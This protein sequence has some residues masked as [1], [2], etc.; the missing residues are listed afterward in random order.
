[1]ETISWI[2][3][4]NKRAGGNSWGTSFSVVLMAIYRYVIYISSAIFGSSFGCQDSGTLFAQ[5]DLQYLFFDRHAVLASDSNIHCEPAVIRWDFDGYRHGFQACFCP[6]LREAEFTVTVAVCLGKSWR[7]AGIVE[8][9]WKPNDQ[10][11]TSTV[12]IGRVVNPK[13]N[14]NHTVGERQSYFLYWNI[15]G[16]ECRESRNQRNSDRC[17]FR[18]RF[19]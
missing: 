11:T 18:L 12:D 7:F 2:S 6:N 3:S 5:Y 17:E 8:V 9:V 15:G 14:V 1:M 16:I 13:R 4:R 19:D 10:L